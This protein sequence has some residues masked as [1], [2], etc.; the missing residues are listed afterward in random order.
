MFGHPTLKLFTFDNLVVFIDGF[1]DLY[2]TWQRTHLSDLLLLSLSLSSRLS[3]VANRPCTVNRT[4]QHMEHNQSSLT[5]AADGGETLRPSHMLPWA[6]ITGRATLLRDG[7]A[8]RYATCR[9]SSGAHRGREGHQIL[10]HRSG[11]SEW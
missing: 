4:A 10:G 2:T 11:R 3:F 5:I 1:S 9:R 6:Y 7:C 8:L